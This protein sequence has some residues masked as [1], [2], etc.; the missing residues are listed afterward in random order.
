MAKQFTDSQEFREGPEHFYPDGRSDKDSPTTTREQKKQGYFEIR[1][2][3]LIELN[4]SKITGAEII[5]ADIRTSEGEDRIELSRKNELGFPAEGVYLYNGGNITTALTANTL[6]FYDN[7]GNQT[8]II[9]MPTSDVLTL[10]YG[11]SSIEIRESQITFYNKLSMLDSEILMP[12]LPTT[13]PGVV[14]QIW[15]DSGTLKI[16]T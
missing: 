8:A 3:K 13:D 5:G 15:N 4:A 6:F 2:L 11:S 9:Q 10:A 7:N 14:G 1:R 12:N 16:S